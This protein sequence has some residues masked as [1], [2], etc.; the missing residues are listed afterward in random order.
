[1]PAFDTTRWRLILAGH[2]DPARGRESLA[3]LCQAYRRPVLAFVRR[4][5]YAPQ[6]AEDLTQGFFESI[7]ER[8]LDAIADPERGRFRT[9]LLTALNR[10]LVTADASANA[11]TTEATPPNPRR[12]T[13]STSATPAPST[14][15]AS[16]TMRKGSLPVAGRT[17]SMP[18]CRTHGAG[19]ASASQ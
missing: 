13:P 15:M 12:R 3:Y 9:L 8:R 10:Y 18:Q 11:R 4:R 2:D 1:M 7:V 16:S 14:R 6:D 5:G 19:S 17:Q